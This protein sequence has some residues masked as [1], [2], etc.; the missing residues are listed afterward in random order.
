[1][2]YLC[3]WTYSLTRIIL[4]VHYV[5]KNIIVLRENRRRI[6]FWIQ[7]QLNVRV[8]ECTREYRRWRPGAAYL[9]MT[10][11]SEKTNLVYIV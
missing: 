6:A 2:Y 4:I 9:S 11:I 1:M 5:L 3:V 8:S 10:Y 7:K